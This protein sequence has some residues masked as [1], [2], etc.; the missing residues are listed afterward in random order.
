MLKIFQVWLAWLKGLRWS[1]SQFFTRSWPY[2]TIWIKRPHLS[3]HT[4]WQVFCA[5]LPS[6]ATQI[7][8]IQKPMLEL[9]HQFLLESDNPRP[10][11]TIGCALTELVLINAHRKASKFGCLWKLLF[12]ASCL[13]KTVY[14][15]VNQ[16]QSNHQRRGIRQDRQRC[17]SSSC[18]S[19]YWV[20]FQIYLQL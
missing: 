14:L 3:I 8:R 4:N 6:S 7:R 20:S 9:P 15:L 2:E 5:L 11:S 18:L 17:W 16:L 1:G 19:S 12:A 10:E 13:D